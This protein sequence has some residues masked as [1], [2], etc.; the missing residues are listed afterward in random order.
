VVLA[1]ASPLGDVLLFDNLDANNFDV[2]S[3]YAVTSVTGSAGA[4]THVI[5]RALAKP[6]AAG[7]PV[8]G[9]L[10]FDSLHYQTRVHLDQAAIL[11][12]KKTML[13]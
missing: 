11:A 3:A 2:H 5:D 13:L 8:R 6:H 7:S 9:T 12:A 1:D 10:A 4:Y